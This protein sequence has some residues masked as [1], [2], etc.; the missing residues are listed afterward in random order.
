MSCIIVLLYIPIFCLQDR[1]ALER[2]ISE[3]E[4]EV[5]VSTIL[6]LLQAAK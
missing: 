6:P 2:K 3:L 4:E 5:K 1:R